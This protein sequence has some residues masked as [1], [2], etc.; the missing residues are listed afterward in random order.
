MWNYSLVLCAKQE[1]TEQPSLADDVGF[2]PPAPND[3]I[4]S[5]CR[6][7]RQ[8]G[9]QSSAR[10]QRRARTSTKKVGEVTGSV[11]AF[12]CPSCSSAFDN[13]ATL[14]R[15]ARVHTGER[16]YSC[17]VCS[18]AFTQSGN[19]TRHI[20]AKHSPPVVTGNHRHQL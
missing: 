10:C 19:L 11:R 18:R 2:Q 14:V 17:P 16:P 7:Y 1:M 8:F 12:V 4:M 6:R 15:H 9:R 5:T 20:R 3:V 13:R